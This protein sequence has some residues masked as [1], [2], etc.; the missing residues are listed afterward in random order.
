LSGLT[1]KTND[2]SR[3]AAA[4]ALASL[5]G[6]EAAANVVTP[7][8][9]QASKDEVLDEK[10]S[11]LR[12]FR[13]HLRSAD[14]IERVE[15]FQSGLADD[16]PIVRELTWREAFRSKYADLRTLALHGWLSS[17]STI[18]VELALPKG[19]SE[20]TVK[21]YDV[22]LGRGLLLDEL[23][24]NPKNEI[25]VVARQIGTR[26]AGQ[27]TQG[28]VILIG[29]GGYLG[30]CSLELHVSDETSMSG[31]VRCKGLD[32]LVATVNLA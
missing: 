20:A 32:P 2:L 7:V 17:H 13:E 21:F 10:I 19:S 22:Q 31:A 12:A 30:T 29:A 18:V 1:R 8:R 3:L 14:D 9:A 28:G 24:I 15:A 6:I 27:F 5:L 26:F 11:R 4:L 16:D 25:T 23:K